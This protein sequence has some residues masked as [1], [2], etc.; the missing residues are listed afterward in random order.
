M[1]NFKKD[2]NEPC[3]SLDTANMLKEIGFNWPCYACYDN[4]GVKGRL[5]YTFGYLD[6]NHHK[7]C[8]ELISAP[9]LAFAQKYIRETFN[10]HITIYSSS[11][12]S[13]MYRITEKGQ[14]L[15]D[16]LYGE[17]FYTYEEAQEEAIKQV[18]KNKIQNV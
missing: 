13:W 9:T 11:Q 8:S 6:H 14:K 18:L 15:E 1:G 17:D 16:G 4:L 3:V 2:Y 12:E 7:Y 10:I 5:Y